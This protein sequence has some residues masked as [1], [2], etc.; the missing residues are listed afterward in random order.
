MF[1]TVSDLIAALKI[2]VTDDASG[3]A[4]T[5]GV[6]LALTNLD[7]VLDNVVGVRAELG[8]RLNLLDGQ[9][10]LNADM[11][12]QLQQSISEI[13]D[14]DLAEAVS[15]LNRQLLALEVA[16]QSFARI[17]NLSLFQFI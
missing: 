14:V 17:Q 13:E 6:N 5:Q 1:T 15:R 10:N 7:Q 3:A 4:V 11:S 8:A 9:A 12:V 2:P 16:Q